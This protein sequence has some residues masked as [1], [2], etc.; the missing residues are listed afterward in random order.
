MRVLNETEV[1]QVSGGSVP[2]WQWALGVFCPPVMVYN[3]AEEASATTDTNVARRAA[4][5]TR[6]LSV[7]V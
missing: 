3:V 1:V 4:S 5:T 7:G 6:L 2:W